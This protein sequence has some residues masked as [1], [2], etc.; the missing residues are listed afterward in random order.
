MEISV[1]NE[2]E[3][4]TVALVGHL[5]TGTAGELEDALMPVIESSSDVTVDLAELEYVSSA[6]LRVLLSAHKSLAAK[7]GKL[8]ITNP[9]DSVREVFEITGLNEALNIE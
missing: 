6:G 2:G 8:T 3:K 7:E 1:T 9:Q 4:A 5:N